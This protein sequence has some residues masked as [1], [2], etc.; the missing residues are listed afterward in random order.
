MI[1]RVFIVEDSAV[2]R[3]RL[4]DMLM[5]LSNVELAGEADNEVDAVRCIRNMQLDVVI[6]DFSLAMGNSQHVLR[7]IKLQ[8]LATRVI[9]LT[10]NVYPQYRKKCME[11]GADYFMDKSRDIDA[12]GSLLTKLADEKQNLARTG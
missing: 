5:H 11:L 1:M 8:P 2:I 9:V 6:L 10:N 12:L 3:E 7:Q 4:S